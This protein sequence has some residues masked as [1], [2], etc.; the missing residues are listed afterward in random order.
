MNSF[1]AKT[2][3]AY[4]G[5]FL[6]EN[7]YF[8]RFLRFQRQL[9]VGLSEEMKTKIVLSVQNTSKIITESNRDSIAAVRKELSEIDAL[10]NDR[11]KQVKM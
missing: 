8:I 9:Y 7:D 11:S 3:N 1:V 2:S 10:M 5:E 6:K 4:D